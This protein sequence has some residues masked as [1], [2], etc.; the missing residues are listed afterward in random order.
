MLEGTLEGSGVC[1]SQEQGKRVF[2]R[3]VCANVQR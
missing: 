1:H 3:T 2:E